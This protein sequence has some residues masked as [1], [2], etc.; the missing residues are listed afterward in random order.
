M[1]TSFRFPIL[2]TLNGAWLYP[3]GLLAATAAIALF[4]LI[5]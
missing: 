3:V 2:R 1:K 5:W 4:F